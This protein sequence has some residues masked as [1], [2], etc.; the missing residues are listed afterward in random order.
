METLFISYAGKFEAHLA[1]KIS[2]NV[3]KILAEL[4][5]TNHLNG[6]LR[7]VI[8]CGCVTGL[9]G[10]AL[11]KICDNRRGIGLSTS[12][13]KQAGQKRI[14]GNLPQTNITDYLSQS[15]L[16]F[17]YFV[18]A[19]VLTDIGDLSILFSLIKLR[20]KRR[21]RLIFSTEYADSG[22]FFLELSGRSS[23][24]KLYMKQVWLQNLAFFYL[25]L[26]GR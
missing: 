20:K 21:R 26:E 24:S 5:M 15:E 14:S 8:D 6:A 2:Y 25:L 19:D 22:S 18:C 17:D 3:P 16:D 7:W 23:H 1:E 4:M 9:T 11:E 13:L 12:M 10:V